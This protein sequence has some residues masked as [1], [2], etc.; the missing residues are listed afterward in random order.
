MG[1]YAF[2]NCY[3]LASVTIPSSV[4]TMG[5]YAFSNCYSLASVTIPSSV[6]TMGNYAFSNCYGMAH[7]YV[8]RTT[9]PTLGGTSVFAGIR[10]DC[11]IHV[12]AAS[13]SE[14]QSATNWSAHKAKMVGDL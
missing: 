8:Y 14:Y 11:V 3:S 7:Y 4:T 10:S 2:S 1:N 6:T 12:P 5:N 9:P 13:L